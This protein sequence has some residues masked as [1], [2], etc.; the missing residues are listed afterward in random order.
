MFPC[1][2]YVILST[3]RQSIPILIHMRASK[4]SLKTNWLVLAVVSD[5]I[6]QRSIFSIVTLV[7]SNVLPL[8]SHGVLDSEAADVSNNQVLAHA[9]ANTS[10]SAEERYTVKF[11]SDFVNEYPR[12]NAHGEDTAGDLDNPNHLLGAFP[13]LF[14]YGMG[15][16][17]VNRPRPISYENHAKWAMRYADKRFRKD[18]HFMFQLFGVIQ[19]RQV[20]RAAVLQ[21]QKKTF[22]DH[23][24][25]FRTLTPH[26]LSVASVEE[27][28]HKAHS[29]P[30]VRSL[31]QHVNAVCTKVIG[32]DE[33]RTNIRALIWGM[34]M[35]KNP[36]SL[37]I[38]LNPSDTHDPIAQV[39]VGEEINLDAFDPDGGPD[40]YHR[41]LNI[42][43]D[44]FGAARFF[45]YVVHAILEHL[46]GVT[47]SNKG[48]ISR[49]VGIFG[50]VEG[51]IGTVEAQGRGTL[52][53]HLIVWLQGTFSMSS[54]LITHFRVRRPFLPQNETVVAIHI[55]PR[56][57]G[58][59]HRFK[60]SRSSCRCY[61]T[62]ISYHSTC[63]SHIIFTST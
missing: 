45:H 3:F 50:V 4:T 44:P 46:F 19:K 15:G 43:S 14:P 32:T 40:A 54:H 59:L 38:T 6:L 60:Y 62:D 25:A 53:L 29:N 48:K 13:C 51:Y 58:T 31:K 9:F 57:S 22:H 27:S 20:C 33:S 1:H 23:E 41:S 52:H 61:G 39:F 17:E 8:Q 28:N 21:V 49:H 16:F 63:T 34:T 11:G 35:I 5:H 18:L 56:T 37:W 12:R 47:I 2:R 55:V 30:V 7:E 42:A 26:D 24:E 36:P 10:A